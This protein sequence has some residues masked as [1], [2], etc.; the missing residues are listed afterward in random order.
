M[1][2]QYHVIENPTPEQWQRLLDWAVGH[3]DQVAFMIFDLHGP[4]PKPLRPFEDRLVTA[5]TTCHYWGDRQMRAVRVLRF[6][7][8]EA[9]RDFLKARPALADWGE[10]PPAIMDPLFYGEDDAPRLWT[11]AHEGLVF[12]WLDENEAAW[13]QTQGL[14]LSPASD[15]IPPIIQENVPCVRHSWGD[16]LIMILGIIILLAFIGMAYYMIEGFLRVLGR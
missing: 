5:F 8:D 1:T 12:L 2:R 15:V 6:Q 10:L 14:P 3:T 13:W 9:L 11:I 7:L 16:R 4:I